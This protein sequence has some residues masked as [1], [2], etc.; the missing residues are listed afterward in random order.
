MTKK[1]EL[2]NLIDSIDDSTIEKICDL[3]RNDESLKKK[4]MTN[5]FLSKFNGSTV[6]FDNGRIKYYAPNG[7]WLFC[8]N[9]EKKEFL[10]SYKNIWSVFESK[11]DLNYQQ[12]KKLFEGILKEHFNLKGFTVDIP[13]LAADDHLEEPFKLM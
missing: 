1:E 12:T 5:F 3:L 6:K 10:V 7:D 13:V 2:K 8:Q 11:Y 9:N 4:E